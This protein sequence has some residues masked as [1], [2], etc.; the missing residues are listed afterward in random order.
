MFNRNL[1][2]QVLKKNTIGPP[3]VTP[4]RNNLIFDKSGDGTVQTTTHAPF[5][6]GSMPS[7]GWN[8][9]VGDYLHDFQNWQSGTAYAVRQE[10]TIVKSGSHSI[11]FE[12]HSTDPVVSSSVR[13]EIEIV[14]YIGGVSDT[15]EM[16]RWYGL[17]YY[18]QD[19]AVD[20]FADS[21]LQWHDESGPCPPL[22]IQTYDGHMWL[23]QC[24][25]GGNTS[26]DLGPIISNAWF[27]VVIHVKWTT[28][29]TGGI[30]MWVNGVKKVNKIN[31]NIK[32]NSPGGSYL[33]IG[34]N[35]F[36]WADSGGAL[37]PSLITQRIFYIDDIRIGNA[38]ATYNDVAPTQI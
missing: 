32:T 16:E 29:T 37:D 2:L 4:P 36:N 31:A 5:D 6:D 10:S 14:N 26:N 11:R 27:E 34:M 28:T 35:K 8:T 9:R 25:S 3:P 12:L 7:D 13:T 18:L 17:S 33:K 21:I 23:Q 24:I 22:S 15:Q 19:W 38:S 1:L 20:G 30:D